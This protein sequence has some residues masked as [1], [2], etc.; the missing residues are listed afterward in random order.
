VRLKVNEGQG[1][2]EILPVLWEDNYVSL[3][4]G[5]KRE[6]AATYRASELGAVKPAVEVKGWN[7]E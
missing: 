4:P 5:E 2:E 6:I 7:T 3:L 1:G